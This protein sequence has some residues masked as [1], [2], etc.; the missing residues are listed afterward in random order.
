MASLADIFTRYGGEYLECHG[1]AVPSQHR[2]VLALLRACGTGD[3]GSVRW[4]CESCGRSHQTPRS[5]GNRHCPGCQ[6][7]KSAHWL[8]EQSER[9]LEV[10]YFL[11]TFTLPATLRPFVRSH[12][13]ASY[14]ALFRAATESLQKLARDPRFLGAA[15]L[16]FT[17][18]L[19]T[20]GRALAYHPHLHVLVPAGGLSDDGETWIASRPDFLVPV[21]ALSKIFRAKFR[22]EMARVGL[23]EQ[24]N[25]AVWTENFITDSR[26]VGD[27]ESTLRYLSRYVFRV[28]I[29]NAR[30]VSCEDGRVRFRWKK[31]GSRRWRTMELDALE[32]IRRFLQH[33][34][35]RGLQKV[36]H[37]GFLSPQSAVSLHEVRVLVARVNLPADGAQIDSAAKAAKATPSTTTGSPTEQPFCSRCGGRLHV[38]AIVFHRVGFRDSR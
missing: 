12:Q 19:H 13:R 28:A 35:P 29:S 21:K 30:I 24:I 15:R 16:G 3:L 1:A 14:R 37:Y 4:H 22:D 23:L 32:F 9:R 38:V 18:V 17:A 11:L 25:P 31:S 10:P 26:A 6:S 2:R 8:A 36:R 33:V 5:C 20:W 7:S 27:G 34:L